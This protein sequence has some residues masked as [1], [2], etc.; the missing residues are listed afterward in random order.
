MALIYNYFIFQHLEFA[1]VTLSEQ[2]EGKGVFCV[3]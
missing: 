2:Q 3:V 1:S